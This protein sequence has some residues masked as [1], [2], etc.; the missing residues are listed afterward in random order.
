MTLGDA[1]VPRSCVIC[2]EPLGRPGTPE[3]LCRRGV[4]RLRTRRWRPPAQNPREVRHLRYA[5]GCH[6][7]APSSH[8]RREPPGQAEREDVHGDLGCE[9]PRCGDQLGNEEELEQE[10]REP[11]KHCTNRARRSPCPVLDTRIS[12][13]CFSNIIPP[14][15]VSDQRVIASTFA[16]AETPVSGD[17]AEQL[18][19]SGALCPDAREIEIRARCDRSVERPEVLSSD[20]RELGSAS[21]GR[22][23]RCLTT[24][25]RPRSSRRRGT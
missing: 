19:C 18:A 24:E 10:A 5:P 9:R 21:K 25:L 1:G 23:R 3:Q 11:S 17:I 20:G 4:D 6:S 2:G 22:C 15:P 8:P 14:T 7:P 12:H 16:N 13:C